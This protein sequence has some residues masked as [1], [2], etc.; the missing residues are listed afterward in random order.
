MSKRLQ[1]GHRDLGHFNVES[2]YEMFIEQGPSIRTFLSGTSAPL[3]TMTILMTAQM[4]GAAWVL[5][6]A[7]GRITGIRCLMV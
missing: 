6:T 7:A 5:R 3:L 2:M 4:P 1:S